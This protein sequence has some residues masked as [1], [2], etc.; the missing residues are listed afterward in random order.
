MARALQSIALSALLALTSAARAATPDCDASGNRL[1]CRLDQVLH[2]LNVTAVL[3]VIVLV[4]TLIFL[5][6]I[7]RRNRNNRKDPHQ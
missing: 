4:P 2:L 1:E 3:L 7:Y 6:H 5:V